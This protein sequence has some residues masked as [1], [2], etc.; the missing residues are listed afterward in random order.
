M[1]DKEQRARE[2]PEINGWKVPTRIW[3]MD[4]GGGDITWCDSPNPDGEQVDSVEYVLAALT[5]ETWR[6]METVNEITRLR[7]ALEPF[8]ALGAIQWPERSDDALCHVSVGN[9]RAAA[10]CLG[11]SE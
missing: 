10:K 11:H 4:L 7:E 3:L 9:L 2:L 1:T 5:D 6:G 8:A